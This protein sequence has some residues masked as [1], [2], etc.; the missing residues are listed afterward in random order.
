[1]D[2]LKT[3]FVSSSLRY[4][5]RND[6][7]KNY[8]CCPS[9][10]FC[11]GLYSPSLE[12]VPPFLRS[13]INSLVD[14]GVYL[15]CIVFSCFFVY[16]FMVNTFFYFSVFRLLFC[17]VPFNV[18]HPSAYRILDFVI[19]LSLFTPDTQILQIY[20][21]SPKFAF[22]CKNDIQNGYIKIADI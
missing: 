18:V 11:Y 6:G 10:C 20:T 14:V 2:L 22:V 13:A 3:H 16:Y 8:Y 5:I 21:T 4:S 12:E 9:K 17:V 15:S 19:Y 1:M 7:P